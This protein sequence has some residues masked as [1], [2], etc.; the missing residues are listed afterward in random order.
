[1]RLLRT[2][3]LPYLVFA[4]LYT[5]FRN[6]THD[7]SPFSGDWTPMQ[8]V[9]PWYL[10]WFL[11]ALFLWRLT[12]PI[13]RL[14]RWPITISIIASL[15][16]GADQ[17]R[18]LALGQVLQ[19]L[20]FFVLGMTIRPELIDR[21]RNLRW[22]RPVAVVV[23]AGALAGCYLYVPV[24]RSEWLY[25]RSGHADLDVSIIHW[26]LHS[27]TQ[28]AVALLL[29]VAFLALVPTNRYGWTALGEGTQYTYLLHGFFI[30]GALAWGFYRFEIWRTAVGQVL[31]TVLAVGLAF[32]L[33]APVVRVT[34]RWIV[35]PRWGWLFRPLEPSRRT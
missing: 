17:P 25:R 21:I 4:T 26:W 31:I 35:E 27:A 9:E 13:W 23:F 7:E 10:T 1:M 16:V 30:Q 18:D 20:P 2:T 33:A 6:L 29:C 8:L 32:A 34:T 28:G 14:V 11:M 24:A 22:R 15:A 3:L 19:F 5:L 12:A